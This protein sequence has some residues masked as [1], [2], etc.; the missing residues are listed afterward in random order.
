MWARWTDEYLKGLRERHNPK[1]KGKEASIKAGD[2]VLIKNDERDRGKWNIGIVVEP[3]K[4]R[5]GVVRSV[6]LRQSR[7]IVCGTRCPTAVSHGTEL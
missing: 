6:K 7:K 5:D 2:A 3:I 1:N 4:G